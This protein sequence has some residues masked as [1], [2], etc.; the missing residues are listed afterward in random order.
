MN[1]VW[2]AWVAEGATPARACIEAKLAR[3]E[4]LVEIRVVAAR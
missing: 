1:G 4:L 3:P 2:D